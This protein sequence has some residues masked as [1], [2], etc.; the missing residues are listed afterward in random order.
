MTPGRAGERAASSTGAGLEKHRRTPRRLPPRQSSRRTRGAVTPPGPA[1][2]GGHPACH[3]DGPVP[4][5]GGVSGFVPGVVTGRWEDRSPILMPR[6]C[7]VLFVWRECRG[8]Q[9]GE[10]HPQRTA[11]LVCPL[12]QPRGQAAGQVVRPQSR[13]PA[14]LD[15]R[16]G[17]QADR[18]LRRRQ[19][20]RDP[21]SRLRRGA[22]GV[23]LI[24]PGGR[25][26]P[27]PEAVGAGPAHPAGLGGTIRSARSGRAPSPRRWAPG[28]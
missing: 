16:G 21:V 28:R 6:S 2:K 10:A 5:K 27:G 20:R 24:A 13:R 1:P 11:A 19:A 7:R 25:H 3:P 8:G 22:L 15:H 12:P 4:D 14:V 23:L 9:S 26:D 18:Q 17:G